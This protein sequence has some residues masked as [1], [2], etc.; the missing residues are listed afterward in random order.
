MFKIQKK[1]IIIFLFIFSTLLNAE[2]Y[3]DVVDQ[4]NLKV[5]KNKNDFK[6]L[7]KEE[8]ELIKSN[9]DLNK[10]KK[11]YYLKILN[12]LKN[13]KNNLNL[14]QNNNKE[15]NKENNK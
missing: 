5:K 3:L 8:L 2:N 12:E 14:N 4:I 1:R 13:K 11:T 6:K 15:N 10:I 7:S 9:L